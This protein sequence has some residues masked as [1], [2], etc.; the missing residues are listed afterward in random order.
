MKILCSEKYKKKE[1]YLKKFLFSLLFIHN[2]S[3]WLFSFRYID[4]TW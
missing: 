1:I 3:T 4:I 2:K